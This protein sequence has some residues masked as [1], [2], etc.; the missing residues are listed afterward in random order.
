[1]LPPCGHIRNSNL[2]TTAWGNRILT[3]TGGLYMVPALQNFQK[4]VKT[5]KQGAQVEEESFNREVQL[6]VFEKE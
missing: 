2:K 4:Q 5:M 3:S 1:M 6:T